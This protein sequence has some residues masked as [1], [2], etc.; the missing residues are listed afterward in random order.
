M[1]KPVLMMTFA[2]WTA[3]TMGLGCG[4]EAG[5]AL[6]YTGLFQR[7]KI[8]AEFTLSP[9]PILILIDDPQGVVDWPV[10][11]RLLNDDLAQELLR[12]KATQ[13]IIPVQTLQSIQQTESDFA[14]RGAREVGE[15]AGAEQ[16]LWVEVRDFLAPESAEEL[17]E[18]AYVVASV[19]VIDVRAANRSAARLWPA[20]PQGKVVSVNRSGSEVMR[21]RTRDGVAKDLSAALSAKIARHFYAY[22]PTDTEAEP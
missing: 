6:Y 19:K 4:P 12:H 2:A 1:R 3:Q 22:R 14:K 15:L 8:P 21:A 17:S 10:F 9:G 7:K 20:N 16:V 11:I 5:A 13:K 18:A